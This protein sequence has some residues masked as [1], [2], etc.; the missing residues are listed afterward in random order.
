MQVWNVLHAARW[1][2]RTQKIAKN[3]SSAHHRTT[4]S[5]DIFATKACVDNRKK[6]LLNS[7]ISSTCFHNYGEL[8][9]IGGWDRFTNLRH[10]SKF[11]WVSGLGFVILITAPTSLN[12]GQTHCA[13]CLAVSWAST[14]YI[15]FRGPLPSNG[16]LPH[17]KFTFRLSLAFRSYI[18]SVTARHS[19]SGCQPNFAAFRRRR[20]PYSA[21][22]PSRGASAHIL[23][24]IWFFR[25]RNCMSF[26]LRVSHPLNQT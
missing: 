2:Y 5:G 18:C 22:R 20:Y 15:H 7:N 11:Q 17:A 25:Y 14:L 21:G 3:L 16:I 24:L 13:R 9:P 10:P 8:R 23:V 4:L 1:K 19:S 6:N 12:G 26:H